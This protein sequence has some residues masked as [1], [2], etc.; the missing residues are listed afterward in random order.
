MKRTNLLW[1]KLRVA[2]TLAILALL[3]IQTTRPVEAVTTLDTTNP[4]ANF[5]NEGGQSFTPGTVL[6]L[7]D[8]SVGD[9]VSFYAP[10]FDASPGNALDLVAT[11]QVRNETR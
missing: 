1:V 11:F 4:T 7:T 5:T 10:D 6:T 2:C 3:A 8:T 9:F